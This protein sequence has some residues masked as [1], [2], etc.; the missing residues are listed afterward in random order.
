MYVLGDGDRIRSRVESLLLGEELE[1][2]RAFSTALTRA[3]RECGEILARELAG[4]VIVSGG[5]DLLVI[6]EN[7]DRRV[8]LDVSRGFLEKTGCTISFGVSRTVESAFIN[9]RRAK[10][11]GGGTVVE[12]V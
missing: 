8:L 12:T 5:D 2:L 11:M 6:A 10:A 9:L 3:I 4:D 1:D 7:Y